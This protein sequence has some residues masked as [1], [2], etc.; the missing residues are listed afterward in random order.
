M[1][2]SPLREIR[3]EGVLGWVLSEHLVQEHN[4]EA[5]GGIPSKESRELCASDPTPRSE[6]NGDEN[7][8]KPFFIRPCG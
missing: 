3:S 4:P 8:R 7:R 1:N 5:T 2:S 6:D